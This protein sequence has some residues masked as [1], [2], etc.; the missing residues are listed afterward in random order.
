MTLGIFVLLSA[1]NTGLLLFLIRKRGWASSEG[2]CAMSLLAMVVTD[3]VEVFVR[4]YWWPETLPLG[5]DEINLRIYP[6]MVHIVG[7]VA[8]MVGLHV[9]D[10]R[11]R[12]ISRVLGRNELRTL[13]RIGGSFVVIG[14]TMYGILLYFVGA[15]TLGAHALDA[16]WNGE[17]SVAGFW[18]RG[19]DIMVVG[20]LLLFVSL[21]GYWRA[22][23]AAAAIAIPTLMAHNKGG[24][25]ESLA[26]AA[27]VCYAYQKRQFR[28]FFRARTTWIIGVPAAVLLVMLTIGAKN[29][30]LTNEG[31]PSATDSLMSGLTAVRSRYSADGLYRGYS[32]M[33]T[34]MRNGWAERLE[35]R[36]LSYTL[37]GWMPGFIYQNK[38][39]HPTHDTGYMIYSDHHSYAGDASAFTLV[40]LAYADFGVVSVVSYLLVGGFVLGR[41]R[42]AATRSGRSLY[43]HVGYVFVCLFGACSSESGLMGLIYVIVFAAATVGLTWIILGLFTPRIRRERLITRGSLQQLGTHRY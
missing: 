6:T 34:Y 21:R 8:L 15:M 3:N 24:L 19:L 1:I 20:A 27:F 11:P 14:A 9:A 40:G 2:L 17:T 13:A 33:V 23:A 29:Y 31:R 37:T 12:S 18:Y 26:W 42:R 32:Q 41:M 35:G 10:P 28:T 5:P 36:L 16:A 30:Y 25:E 39:N 22:I 7:I 4:V 43:Y 38:P